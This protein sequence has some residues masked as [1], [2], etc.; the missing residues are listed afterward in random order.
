LGSPFLCIEKKGG[1]IVLS[2]KDFIR[3]ER[4][5]HFFQPIFYMDNLKKLGYEMLLRSTDYPNPE[6]TFQEAKKEKQLYELDSRSIHKAILTYQLA[7][8]ARKSGKLFLNIFPST[9]L[10]PNFPSFINQIISDNYLNSQQIVFEISELE[11]IKDFDIFKNQI[12]DLKKH[13]FLIAVDDIGRG[14][15]NFKCIIELEP[16]YLKLDRYLAQD[17]HL[18][19]EKQAIIS[20]FLNY[21]EQ[22]KSHLI[23]EGI[24]KDIEMAT[25]KSMGVSIA[26]GYIFGKP[27]S[28]QETV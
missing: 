15:F 16:N 19:K 27:S 18:F 7:G 20:F 28:L 10:N 22:F 1:S 9:V 23:L 12:S 14:Y 13:G 21:C 25:A 8:L 4:F 5:Y 3:E 24:E 26:Q 2:I 11:N 17:L 6:L